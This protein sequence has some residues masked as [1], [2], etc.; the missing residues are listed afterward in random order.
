ML[1]QE[2]L[3]RMHT[4]DMKV[5]LVLFDEIEKASDRTFMLRPGMSQVTSVVPPSSRSTVKFS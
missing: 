3:D 4:D 5:S 2:N 1:T